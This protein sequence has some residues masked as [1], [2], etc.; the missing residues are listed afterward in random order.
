MNKGSFWI[1][2]LIA[3]SIASGQEK[4]KLI[5]EVEFFGYSG[6]NLTKLRAA[7]PFR[8]GDSFSGETF[9]AKLEPAGEAIKRVSGQGPTDIATVC[10]DDRGNWVVF[11]GLSGK[12][13]SYNPP[14][15]GDTRLPQNIL[16]LYERFIKGNMEDAQRGA[17]A[18]DRSEG[19]AL[20]AHPPLRSSQLEMRA[21]AVGH[22]RL[23]R[24]V[25]ETASDDQ[26]RIVAAELLG[27]AQQSKSQIAALVRASRDSNGTVRNNATRALLVLAESSPKAATEIPAESF[28]ELLLS[29][30]WTDL[31][32]VSGLF[33]ALT[34]SRNVKL[35]EQLRRR[36]VLERLIEMA[37][38]RSHGEA[39]R[40]IVGRVAGIDESRLEGLVRG[41]KVEA[42]INELPGK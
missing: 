1:V 17:S 10:C 40:Y 4:P 27:Y 33:Y 26:Q 39:A 34:K 30:T 37:R 31:N 25:L 9:A 22:D 20:S 18:E 11:I 24:D 12:T 16:D 38:W 21:Y 32:K 14:P 19:Y 13:T 8:E 28:I 29:G 3:A 6:I 7:L 42:I 23:L 2:I 5:G 15:K 35:L 36:E 41:G